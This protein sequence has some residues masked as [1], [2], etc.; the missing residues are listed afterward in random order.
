MHRRALREYT[1][2]YHGERNHQGLDNQLIMPRAVR[3]S[4]DQRIDCK[5]RLGGTLRFHERAAA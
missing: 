3:S 2:H 4:N 5:S 1:I